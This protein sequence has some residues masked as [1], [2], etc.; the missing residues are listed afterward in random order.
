MEN[1]KFAFRAWDALNKVMK[2]FTLK[3]LVNDDKF[4]YITEFEAVQSGYDNWI[5][6]QFTGQVYEG[7]WL[8][9]GDIVQIEYHDWAE[10]QINPFNEDLSK[11]VI[12]LVCD[13]GCDSSFHLKRIDDGSLSCYAVAFGGSAVKRIHIIGNVYQNP[14]LLKTAV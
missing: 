13:F 4:N 10:R 3:E 7:V 5:W 14:E 11:K 1:R 6:M 8:F 12:R 2:Q 9:E